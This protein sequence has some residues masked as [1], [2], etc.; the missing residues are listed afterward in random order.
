[1]S[2]LTDLSAIEMAARLRTGD[3][4]PVELV[5]AHLKRIEDLNPQLTAYTHIDSEGARKAARKSLERLGRKAPRGPLDGVPLSVK[6]S[7]AVRGFPWECGS[8]LR[9]GTRADSDAPTVERLRGAGAVILG[10][11]NAPEFLMAWETNN[12]LYG[13]T[14]NPWRRE[15]TAGGSSGGESAAIAARISA[16]GIGSDGGGSIRVPAHFTGI[17]GLKPTPGR[18]PAT[19]HFPASAGPFAAIGV[20][21][22]MARTAEDTR[23]LFEVIAGPDDGD[24][25]AAP[26]P[27]RKLSW[28]QVRSLKIGV[29][30][31]DRRTPVTPAT[32]KAVRKAAE[33]LRDRGFVVEDFR[34]EN[35]EEIRQL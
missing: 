5:D 34:P 35:L 4:S 9:Q 12:A 29:F 31:D 2:E 10:N 6:S 25:Y 22:P 30:E 7:I 27:I 18:V 20:L 1:V 28:E 13:H 32:R 24:P 11:T 15:R 33:A 16:G 21:G 19:G 3:I 8:K 17:C 23:L 26:V 14:D